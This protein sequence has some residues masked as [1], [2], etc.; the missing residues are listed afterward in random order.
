MAATQEDAV[1]QN[2]P[3]PDRVK[4][5]QRWRDNDTRQVHRDIEVLGVTK[6]EE[7]VEYALVERGGR[8]R[9]LRTDRLYINHSR[10]YTYLGGP[11]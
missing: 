4:K 9:R 3:K 11:Q 1:G 7:G 2:L 5:G 8:K 10:G 6:D